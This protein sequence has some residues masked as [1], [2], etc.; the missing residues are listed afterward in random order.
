M[1]RQP[2]AAVTI[3]TGTQ[4]VTT[5]DVSITG[6][7]TANAKGKAIWSIAMDNLVKTNGGQANQGWGVAAGF[8]YADATA[9]VEL[10]SNASIQAGGKV[11]ITSDV[12]STGEMESRVTLN[13]G[14]QRTDPK[15]IEVALAGAYNKATSKVTID[16]DAAIVAQKNVDITASATDETTVKPSTASYRDGRVGVVFGEATVKGTVE[17]IVQGSITAGK[18]IV[19]AA[20]SFNPA[21]AVD[22]AARA[23]DF[24]SSVE[25]RTGDEVIYSPGDGGAIPGLVAGRTYYAIVDPAAATRLRLAETAADAALGRAVDF[26]AGYPTLTTPKGTLPIVSVDADGDDTLWFGFDRWPDGVP[27]FADGQTVGYAPV[28]GQFLGQNDAAGS[29]IGPLPAGNYTVQLVPNAPGDV[30]MRIR[31]LD[32]AGTRID[33]NANPQFV[34]EAGAIYQVKSFDED[35]ATVSF[36]EQVALSN[37]QKI[38]YVQAFGSVVT[39]LVDGR[40][41]FAVVDPQQ[42]GVIQLADSLDQARA[43]DPA[44]QNAVPTLVT[45]ESDPASRRTIAIG[46]VHPA[47]GLVFSDDP[48]LTAGTPVVYRA[49]PGKPVGGLVDG[50]TYYAYP[51]DNPYFDPNFPQYVVGLRVA[52]DPASPLIDYELLKVFTAGDT[53]LVINGID[54]VAGALSLALPQRAVVVSA[55]PAMLVGGTVAITTIPAG[56]PQVWNNATGGTF[57]ISLPDGDGRRQTAAIPFDATPAAVRQAINVLGLAGVAVTA[58]YGRGV[59]QAPWTLVGTGLDDLQFD[60]TNLAGGGA[61]WSRLTREG[62]QAVSTTA[63][64]GTF[65]LTLDAAGSQRAT[66]AIPFNASATAVQA[67]FNGIAGVLAGQVTGSGRPDDPWIAEPRIQPLR[68]GDPVVFRDAWGSS[69]PGLLDGQTYYVVV[70]PTVEQGRDDSVVV[71]LAATPAA[72]IAPEPVVVPLSTTIAFGSPTRLVMSGTGQSITSTI[73]ATGINLAARLTSTDTLKAASANGNKPGPKE[74]VTQGDFKYASGAFT[75]FS[76]KLSTVQQRI[77]DKLG[78]QEGQQSND[79]ITASASV[80]YLSID[81]TARVLVDS[82]AVLKATGAVNISSTLTENLGSSVVAEISKPTAGQYGV[83][84]AVDVVTV[85]NRS[86]AIVAAGAQVTGGDGVTVN[87][88]TTYPWEG[89]LWKSLGYLDSFSDFVGWIKDF[90]KILGTDWHKLLV[91]HYSASGARLSGEG[92]DQGRLEWSVAGNVSWVGISNDTVAR[93][94]DGAL[95]N[96]DS[97]ILYDD[98]PVTVKADTTM[99]QVGFTGNPYL[100]RLVEGAKAIG[101]SVG[102]LEIANNTRALLGGMETDSAGTPLD[103]AYTCRGPDAVRSGVPAESVSIPPSRARVLFAISR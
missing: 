44:V 78:S 41:Y 55:D 99:S 69:S 53:D 17:V 30:G 14:L 3:G 35:M 33:L 50:V 101:G 54:G 39:G 68:T 86:H 91:T 70:A 25:F 18:V 28:T 49:V 43:A 38:R 82:T 46:D 23:I 2:S 93:I 65:T 94:E 24:P 21:L 73:E 36:G 12:E 56:S 7:A 66:A 22:F 67:S 11:E 76:S 71:R 61:V 1:V 37:A 16:T 95:I 27:L 4:I 79:F 97:S 48:Q 80:G 19:P 62:L 57:T 58:A 81:N 87:A 84:V 10:E 85:T 51:L 13:Q 40:D 102:Y 52:A 100:Y 77:T 20:L 92:G 72:A 74:W 15:N 34:T 32:A 96:Q 60:W 8:S 88:R 47:T 63:S 98:T 59:Y 64:G 5:G 42:P 90:A 31:L 26:G 6:K 89:E 9:T 75:P 29:L 103:P 45:T 83:A